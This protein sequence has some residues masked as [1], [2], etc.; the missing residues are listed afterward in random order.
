VD[1]LSFDSWRFRIEQIS[2]PIR[3]PGRE[4]QER[5]QWASS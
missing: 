4:A 2:W 1:W 3:L 5:R